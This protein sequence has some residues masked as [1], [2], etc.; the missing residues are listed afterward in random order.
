MFYIKVNVQVCLHGNNTF[1]S[2]NSQLKRYTERENLV[3]KFDSYIQSFTLTHTRNFQ[4]TKAFL[5]FKQSENKRFSKKTLN[6]IQI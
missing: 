1:V 5:L 2:G 4:M 3:V 6:A